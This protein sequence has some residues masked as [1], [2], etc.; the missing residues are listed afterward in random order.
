MQHHLEEQQK[1]AEQETQHTLEIFQ[2]LLQYNTD[3]L[4]DF[5]DIDSEYQDSDFQ[6][7][8]LSDP[9]FLLT[10]TYLPEPEEELLFLDYTTNMKLEEFFFTLW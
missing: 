6:D 1:K 8:I 9:P 2:Q 5:T 7:I 3:D 4:S 10:T